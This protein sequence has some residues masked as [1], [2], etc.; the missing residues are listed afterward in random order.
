MPR[1]RTCAPF[2]FCA[3]PSSPGPGGGRRWADGQMGMGGGDRFGS[4]VPLLSP[5][6]DPTNPSVQMKGRA[7][8]GTGMAQTQHKTGSACTT[9]HKS[10]WPSGCG[11]WESPNRDA[12]GTT[13]GTV[14]ALQARSRTP[15]PTSWLDHRH[16]NTDDVRVR[17][18]Y[19]PL[20]GS[21]GH[22]SRS[23]MHRVERGRGAAVRCGAE[24][25]DRTVQYIPPT[26]PASSTT[27]G[28]TWTCPGCMCCRN[29]RVRTTSDSA[30]PHGGHAEPDSTVVLRRPPSSQL[31]PSHVQDQLP[32][33]R[34]GK[35]SSRRRLLP[36]Q[37]EELAVRMSRRDRRPSCS[38]LPSLPP[39]IALPPSDRMCPTRSFRW[40][41]LATGLATAKIT[42]PPKGGASVP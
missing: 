21:G 27:Y 31:R 9:V 25:L 1:P 4:V 2:Y 30:V 18:W 10:G 8:R 7:G 38:S 42:T 12:A 29:E 35:S 16:A 37:R 34:L 28:G 22:P 19:Q 3:C 32:P 5:K 17:V 15:N 41:R 39:L 13:Y 23:A 20:G 14:W 33:R 40:A 6:Q 24:G 36:R 26:Q 11:P